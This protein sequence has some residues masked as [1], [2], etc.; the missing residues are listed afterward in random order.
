[1]FCSGSSS[2]IFADLL[3]LSFSIC[4]GSWSICIF[5]ICYT[6]PSW[7]KAGQLGI[8]THTQKLSGLSSYC[9]RVLLCIEWENSS[10][11]SD[12]TAVCM[13]DHFCFLRDKC[14]VMW[15]H[16]RASAKAMIDAHV[17]LELCLVVKS[18]VSRWSG[19]VSYTRA[20]IQL[21]KTYRGQRKNKDHTYLIFMSKNHRD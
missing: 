9:W 10:P 11:L 20:S 3:W 12:T 19:G 7:E 17:W 21:Y 6:G 18:G 8:L 2:C 13:L 4:R 16:R 14:S 15:W 5:S 1:M